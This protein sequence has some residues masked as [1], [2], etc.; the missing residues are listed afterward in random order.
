[1]TERKT[2]EIQAKFIKKARKHRVEVYKNNID[3]A[4]PLQT[5]C[6]GFIATK[7]PTSIENLVE[8]R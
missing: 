8:G 6:T 7:Y 5:I 4:K 3:R 1:M 2:R